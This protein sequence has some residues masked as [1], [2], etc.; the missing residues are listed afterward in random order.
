MRLISNTLASPFQITRDVLWFCVILLTLVVSFA[1]MFFT[2]IIPPSC[3]SGETDVQQCSQSEYYLKVY[4]ILLGDFGTFE[5]EDF[6]SVFS[7]FLVV[8]YSFMVVLVLLNVLIAVASD[9]YEKC[10]LRSQSLF[11]RARVTMIAELVSFQNLLRRNALPTTDVVSPTA[12]IY[13]TWWSSDSWAHGWSRGS[14]VFFSLS[15]LV[16]FIW[17]I[18][19]MAGYLSGPRHGNIFLSMGSVLI[20]VALFIGIMLFLSTGAADTGSR[21]NV[22]NGEDNENGRLQ[23]FGQCYN[24]FLKHAMRYL[25]GSSNEKEDNSSVSDDW[26]GR[27]VF[28]QREM[29]RISE[30]TKED[31]KQTSKVLETAITQTEERLRSEVTSLEKGL[32]E[33]RLELRVALQTADERKAQQ[34]ELQQTM[35]QVLEIFRDTGVNK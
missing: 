30:A 25:L 28:L 19:E 27:L 4:A 33:L 6:D 22:F 12:P 34:D 32:A 1:Q 5:R 15:S 26:S 10:L 17:V 11:G 23:L 24:G 9:S 18:G 35:R 21:K 16:V 29:G 14:A 2:L 3:S 7:V 8:V 20:N 13:K 31:S